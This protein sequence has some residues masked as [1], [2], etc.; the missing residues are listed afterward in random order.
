M[1]RQPLEHEYNEYVKFTDKAEY[2]HDVQQSAA[3]RNCA[4]TLKR[5]VRQVKSGVPE[6]HRFSLPAKTRP[7]HYVTIFHGYRGRFAR[8]NLNDDE[9]SFHSS[10]PC[11]KDVLVKGSISRN[12]TP[13][14][15][16]TLP[17]AQAAPPK[18][19]LIPGG[20]PQAHMVACHRKAG[21][22]SYR[23]C[24]RLLFYSGLPWSKG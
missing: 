3:S 16:S 9:V 20:L 21:P 8:I 1:H 11:C 18:N 19:G 10:F 2:I 24:G 6:F 17:S 12:L 4:G 23:E 15:Q 5:I 7:L 13:F 22:I 14:I